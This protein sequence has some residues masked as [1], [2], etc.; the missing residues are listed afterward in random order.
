MGAIETIPAEEALFSSPHAALVFALN[1]SGQAYSPPLMNRLACD[2]SGSS[3]K[4]LV[5]LDGAAQAGF[6]LAELKSLGTLHEAVLIAQ[7]AQ[8]MERCECRRAC[9][10]GEK[11]NP[12]WA[13]AIDT[14]T[15]AVLGLALS[16]CVSNY[17]LRRGMVERFFGA[18]DRKIADLAAA[19]DVSDN[20]AANHN[21]KITQALRREQKLAWAGFEDRM[22]KTGMVV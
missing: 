11:P 7:V 22:K 9:C 12:V 1:Y 17:R 3:G 2:P 20:T 5:G 4:G 19:C 21:Q 14:L 15:G 6:V 18:P 8:R 10:S 16:G 13:E